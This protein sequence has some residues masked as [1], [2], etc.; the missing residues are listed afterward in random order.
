M[1]HDGIQGQNLIERTENVHSKEMGKIISTDKN[2]Q[3]KWN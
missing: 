3:R 2:G 1:R